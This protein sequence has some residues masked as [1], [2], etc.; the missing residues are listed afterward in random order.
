MK[1]QINYKSSNIVKGNVT[2]VSSFKKRNNVK[3]YVKFDLDWQDIIRANDPEKR[4]HEGSVIL[5]S[6]I[7]YELHKNHEHKVY[8]S[9]YWMQD[10]TKKKADQ[11]ARRRKQIEHI[12]N[13][14][15]HRK[16]FDN[17]VWLSNVFEVS[18]QEG[19]EEILR[20]KDVVNTTN[21]NAAIMPVQTSI[22][23]DTMP[24]KSGDYIDDKG[25]EED[26][27]GLSSS[28]PHNEKLKIKSFSE[29]EPAPQKAITEIPT[30][31]T[32]Y[33]TEPA[34]VYQTEEIRSEANAFPNQ[35]E[36]D[37]VET[38]MALAEEREHYASH[39]HRDSGSGLAAVQDI[40][41]LANFLT[42]TENL[43]SEEGSVN[44]EK[45]DQIT[46]VKAE[47]FRAFDNKTSEEI[48]ENCTFTELEPNKLGISIKADFSLNIGDK[49]KLK[50]CIRAVYGGDVQMVSTPTTNK[51]EITQ[52]KPQGAAIK[53]TKTEWES[54]KHQI[55]DYF[56]ENQYN[57]VKST[58]LDH[59]CYSHASQEKII[60]VGRCFYVDYITDKFAVAIE[61]AVKQTKKSLIFQYEG[62]AQRPIIYKPNGV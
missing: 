27:L 40:P 20:L 55:A 21:T 14:T 23:A 44:T 11:T 31:A 35:Q 19:Y 18:Y 1:T 43:P 52:S 50:T 3:P 34:K 61:E 12:F 22:K 60:V 48:M 41:I 8:L 58:W 46:Q 30:L 16:V 47:I 4:L 53:Q 59:L 28:D 49:E 24:H 5:A 15:W 39:Q 13:I 38:P 29:S 62:N 32:G 42:K 45:I 51:Q 17:G 9:T 36:T 7:A 6:R 2:Y 10:V 54:M 25:S 37:P 57:H 33:P 26:P 56:P